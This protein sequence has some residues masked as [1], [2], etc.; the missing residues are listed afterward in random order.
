MSDKSETAKAEADA[1]ISAAI[2]AG[3]INP[4]MKFGE[5]LKV[6]ADAKIGTLGYVAAWERYALIVK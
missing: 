5:L 2:R 4:D 3:L 6:G 1:A